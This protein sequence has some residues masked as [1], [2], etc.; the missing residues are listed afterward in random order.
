MS[1][2]E[3]ISGCE[4][5]SHLGTLPTVNHVATQDND[6]DPINARSLAFIERVTS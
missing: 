3:V 6:R 4:P 2:V 5:F 1:D